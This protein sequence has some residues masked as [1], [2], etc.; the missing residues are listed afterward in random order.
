VVEAGVIPLDEEQ[1]AEEL[2]AQG[3]DPGFLIPDWEEEDG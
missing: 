1:C 2:Y 3:S